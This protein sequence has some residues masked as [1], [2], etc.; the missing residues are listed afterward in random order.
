[1]ILQLASD[2]SRILIDRA[3]IRDPLHI[4]PNLVDHYLFSKLEKIP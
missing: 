2:P 4:R 1:M 3:P